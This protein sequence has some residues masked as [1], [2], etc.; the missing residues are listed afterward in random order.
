V[1]L[2]S[3]E[4]EDAC[5]FSIFGISLFGVLVLD[6]ECHGF[7]MV[8]GYPFSEHVDGAESG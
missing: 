4:S 7:L 5:E 6:V 8:T 3:F 2:E 1:V